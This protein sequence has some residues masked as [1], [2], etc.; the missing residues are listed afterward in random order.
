MTVDM[1]YYT[2]S[3]VLD[4]RTIC[5]RRKFKTRTQAI[6]YAFDKLTLRSQVMYEINRG[7]H[8]IEYV[9]NNFNRIFVNRCID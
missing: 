4:S 9:C 2:L 6:N 3:Y 5:V 8:F 7:N 1:K